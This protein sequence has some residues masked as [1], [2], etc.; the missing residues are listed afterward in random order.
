MSSY[1]GILRGGAPVFS[2]AQQGY[3]IIKRMKVVERNRAETADCVLLVSGHLVPVHSDLAAASSGFIRSALQWSSAT[4]QWKGRTVRT[5][6][7]PDHAP[8]IVEALVVFMYTGSLDDHDDIERLAAIWSAA[9]FLAMT[10][11]V[12][13]AAGALPAEVEEAAGEEP[14]LIPALESMAKRMLLSAETDGTWIVVLALGR[15]YNRPEMVTA[16]NEFAAAHLGSVSKHALWPALPVEDLA[17]LLAM[18]EVGEDEDQVLDAALSWLAHHREQT[19]NVLPFVRPQY[20]SKEGIRTLMQAL[21]R[22]DTSSYMREF[23]TRV[24]ILSAD[25]TW[26]KYRGAKNSRLVVLDD[27]RSYQYDS[28]TSS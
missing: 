11:G 13:A 15:R 2:P 12:S 19:E 1:F 8:D 16:A 22:S 17:A 18:N 26:K 21:P 9:D 14:E 5:V 24:N 27:R 23:S 20:L 10:G 7:I 25:A 4:M 6:T 28:R 3:S